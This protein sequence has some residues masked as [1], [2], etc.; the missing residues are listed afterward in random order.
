MPIWLPI[1]IGQLYLSIMW[2]GVAQ[3]RIPKGHSTMSLKEIER[4]AQNMLSVSDSI[5]NI[6]IYDHLTNT[7]IFMIMI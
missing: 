1:L 4:R 6:I 2:L 5:V 7:K 3:E